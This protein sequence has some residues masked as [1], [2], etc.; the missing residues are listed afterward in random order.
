[1]FPGPFSVTTMTLPD[2]FAGKMHALLF[3]DYQGWVKGRDWYD[4]LWFLMQKVPLRLIHLQ[5]RMHEMGHLSKNEH[6]SAEK[7]RE[8]LDYRIRN[9]DVD[10]AQAD[11]RRFLKDSWKIDQWSKEYFLQSAAELRFMFD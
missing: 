6:L 4:F 3:R 2:L 7:L 5:A 9:L 1:M 10:S 11:V 8:L